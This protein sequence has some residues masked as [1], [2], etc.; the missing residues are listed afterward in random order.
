MQVRRA[1]LGG[2]PTRCCR[3]GADGRPAR[4]PASRLH[5]IYLALATLGF[6]QIVQIVIEEFADITGGV[7]GLIV[8]KAASIGDVR[9]SEYQLF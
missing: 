9:L 3:R 7:R 4:A 2:D 8:P 6:L 5:G 1:V